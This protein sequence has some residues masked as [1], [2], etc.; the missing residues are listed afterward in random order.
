MTTLRSIA[1]LAF[2]FAPACSMAHAPADASVVGDAS[3]FDPRC[4]NI[5]AQMDVAAERIGVVRDEPWPC[6]AWIQTND[7]ITACIEFLRYDAASE[8]EVEECSERSE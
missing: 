1:I 6:P 8:T 5:Y 7:D 3:A 2:F 4:G